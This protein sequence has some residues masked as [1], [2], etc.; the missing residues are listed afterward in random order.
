MGN[1]T[2][3]NFLYVRIQPHQELQRLQFIHIN[4]TWAFSASSVYFYFQF[5][6]D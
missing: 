2:T 4:L 3:I 1:Q 5:G 6:V